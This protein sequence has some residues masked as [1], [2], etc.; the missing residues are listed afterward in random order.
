MAAGIGG[1]F[2]GIFERLVSRVPGVRAVYS[3]S[4][5]SPI[6]SS[7]SG[8]SRLPASWPSSFPARA[9]GRSGLSPAT[10]RGDLRR[11]RRAGLDRFGAL[12]ADPPQRLHDQRARSECIDLNITFDQACQF[13]ISCGV[14]VPPQQCGTAGERKGSQRDRCT[15]D[16]A[17]AGRLDP[18]H[19][20]L[21]PS[22]VS[23]S[24]PALVPWPAGRPSGSPRIA[25][26]RNRGRTGADRH[27]G[28]SAP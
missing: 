6:S 14:V 16:K 13:I 21:V 4:S 3:A 9:C 11:G 7:A 10:L 1:F 5:R 19:Y 20:P 8:K 26:A 17:Q 25:A 2:A 23:A 28:R 24:A 22:C 15:V 12:L 27:H 18:S